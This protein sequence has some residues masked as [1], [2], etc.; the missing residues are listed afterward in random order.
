[1]VHHLIMAVIE[2]AA[3]WLFR[4]FAARPNG[5]QVLPFPAL[6]PVP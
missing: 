3:A 5:A 1:M 2:R 4:K 6:R